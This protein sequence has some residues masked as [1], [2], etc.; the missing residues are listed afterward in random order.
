MRDR[1][2]EYHSRL[3]SDPRT[4]GVSI[5]LAC[6]L[7][8]LATLLVFP[9]SRH[10]ESIEEAILRFGYPGPT[11]Y[12]R[13]IRVRL[14]REGLAPSP[15]NRILGGIRKVPDQP[16][17]AEGTPAPPK[18]RHP[19]SRQSPDLAGL[20]REGTIGSLLR[21]RF[22]LPTVQS[23]ELVIV[24]LVKPEYPAQA[25]ERN[26]EG[27]VELLALVNEQ[28]TVD[29]VEIVKS[30]GALLDQAATSAVRRCRFVPYKVGGKVQAVYADFKFNFTLLE[31]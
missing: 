10:S 24:T 7:T 27:R 14:T 30:A 13:E 19:S 22:D 15:P 11:R 31:R 3:D 25:V 28:G 1:T 20:S 17:G 9:P 6:L 4:T 29:A 12:S 8:Y 26:I 2:S 23:E 5:A 16:Q 18:S 21:H